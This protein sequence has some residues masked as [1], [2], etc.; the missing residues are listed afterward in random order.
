MVCL[1]H[2]TESMSIITH[3]RMLVWTKSQNKIDA[4]VRILCGHGGFDVCVKE[5]Q[6]CSY[7]NKNPCLNE[8]HKE[9]VG[10]DLF[11]SPSKSV[12]WLSVADPSVQVVMCNNFIN[13]VAPPRWEWIDPIAT[14]E[15]EN[16][17]NITDSNGSSGSKKDACLESQGGWWIH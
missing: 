9:Q 14:I 4:R 10:E 1:D 11:E 6:Q 17:A 8:T 13:S 7:H 3:A 2:E 5:T 12:E 15:I 16:N